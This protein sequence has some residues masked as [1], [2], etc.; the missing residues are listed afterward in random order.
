MKS[1]SFLFWGY[2]VIWV[3]LAAY[4]TFLLTRLKSVAKRLDR[5]ERQIEREQ[6]V[7]PSGAPGGS[8]P[9]SR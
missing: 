1:Y 7:R 3:G 6:T 8:G 2:T 9:A 4:L 5:L